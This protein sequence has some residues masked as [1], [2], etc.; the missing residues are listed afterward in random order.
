MV[1]GGGLKEQ[2]LG[3]W[4]SNVMFICIHSDSQEVNNCMSQ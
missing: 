2:S 4:E 1:C 3:E